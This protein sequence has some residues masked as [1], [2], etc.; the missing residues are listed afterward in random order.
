MSPRTILA[1]LASSTVAVSIAGYGYVVRH[2]FSAREK[3][4]A[5]ETAIARRLRR[6]ATPA[7][8]R[9]R[10][11][12]LPAS[13]AVITEGREHFADHCALCHG[14]DGAGRT[15]INEGLYPPAPDL[16]AHDTQDLTDG[17]LFAIIAN[18]VR[19]TGMP[20]WGGET[21]ENWN[22][23]RFIR[24]LPDLTPEE[25]HAM[26]AGPDEHDEHDDEHGH[27]HH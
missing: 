23:V 12:P 26:H 21:D 25:L 3:P 15:T 6:L 16:R 2:G 24:H 11:N 4:S 7:S 20:G 1:I 10:P 27:H 13:P 14:N 17:E 8:V 19:F 5:L 18:G 9:D 22:L